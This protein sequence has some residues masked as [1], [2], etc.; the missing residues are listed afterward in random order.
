MV[1]LWG[2]G[3][4]SVCIEVRIVEIMEWVWG[5]GDG[6][7]IGLLGGGGGFWEG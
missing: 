2:L 1:E 7:M 5:L 6:G 3:C 4:V